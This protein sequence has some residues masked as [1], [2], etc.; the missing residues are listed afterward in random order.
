MAQGS[1]SGALGPLGAWSEGAGEGEPPR[2]LLP[3]AP[4]PLPLPPLPLL[5]AGAVRRRL[6][7][8]LRG[9]LA[10]LPGAPCWH[11][12]WRAS[13]STSKVLALGRQATPS[14]S[15][16]QVRYSSITNTTMGPGQQQQ[17]NWHSHMPTARA[18]QSHMWKLLQHQA[19]SCAS[20][21]RRVGLPTAD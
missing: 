15:N 20:T 1:G 14:S 11:P 18:A 3:P 7:G 5:P 12:S 2:L 8:A 9:R 13:L 16:V 19:C 10:L 4:A 17:A 21:V 6:L